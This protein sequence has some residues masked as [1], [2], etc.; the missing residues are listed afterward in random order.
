MERNGIEFVD[1]SE[2][3]WR[4]LRGAWLD[5]VGSRCADD[6]E[7]LDDALALTNAEWRRRARELTDIDCFAQALVD[8]RG[9]WLGFVSG[10]LDELAIDRNVF[11][12]HVHVLS[13]QSSGLEIEDLLLDRVAQWAC[14]RLADGV[15]VGL[16]EDRSDLVRRFEDHG[17]RRTGVRRRSELGRDAVEVEL[18]MGLHAL[19][20]PRAGLA[21][22]N[23]PAMRRRAMA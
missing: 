21:A 23:G 7:T 22:P 19:Q 2:G 17:F 12:T 13:G 18:A 10:Y 1:V 15:V 6:L 16:R 8:E 11:I 20:V 4:R 5:M 3:D 9:Q 14:A